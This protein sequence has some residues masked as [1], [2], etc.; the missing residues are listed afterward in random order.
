MKD[1]QIEEEEHGNP[2][3][4]LAKSLVALEEPL[5][6]N[7]DIDAVV[8]LLGR[9]EHELVLYRRERLLKSYLL[10]MLVLLPLIG[11]GFLIPEFM[12]SLKF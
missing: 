2:F 9:I 4:G 6:E 10:I 11:L 3:A 7:R 5:P 1:V 8:K 12:R